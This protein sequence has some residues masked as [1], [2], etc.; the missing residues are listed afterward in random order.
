MDRSVIGITGSDT[1]KGQ[2]YKWDNLLK[3]CSGNGA[4][5]DV[6]KGPDT[7]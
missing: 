7:Q 5:K 3:E 1:I 4:E 6:E 2:A